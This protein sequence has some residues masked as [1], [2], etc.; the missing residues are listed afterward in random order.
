[1]KVECG[2]FHSVAVLEDGTLQAWGDNKKNQCDIPD[3]GSTKVV[4]VTCGDAHNIA[5]MERGTLIAWGNNKYGQCTIPKW[6]LHTYMTPDEDAREYRGTAVPPEVPTRV[7]F[8]QEMGPAGPRISR[9][10]YPAYEVV[11]GD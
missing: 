10:E 9:R 2:D 3:F 8:V 7:E 5:T 1:M 11:R 4:G 6:A